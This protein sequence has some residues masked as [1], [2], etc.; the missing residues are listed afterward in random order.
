M[1]VPFSNNTVGR[2]FL[3][4]AHTAIDTAASVSGIVASIGLSIAAEAASVRS[5]LAADLVGLESIV[6][7]GNLPQPVTFLHFCRLS[8]VLPV[9][10]RIF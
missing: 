5:Q 7:C 1:P 3:T 10:Y 2:H 8:L 9:L 4:A 6:A